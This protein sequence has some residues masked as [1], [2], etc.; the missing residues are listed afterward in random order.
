MS[1]PIKRI[2]AACIDGRARSPRYIQKQLCRLHDALVE[3]SEA[4]REAIRG[5][6]HH[7][8]AE[9]ETEYYLALGCLKEQYSKL[10][11]EK[12]ITEEYNLANSIDSPERRV[13]AGTVYIVPSKYTLFYSTISPVSAAIAAGNCVVVEVS[14]NEQL[15]DLNSSY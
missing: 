4:I 10:N 6:T 14:L 12:F 11:V 5:D 7:T 3:N 13:A 9:V 8:A 15:H 2:N 1:S